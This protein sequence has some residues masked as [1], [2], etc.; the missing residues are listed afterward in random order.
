MLFRT[1]T[2]LKRLNK[3]SAKWPYCLINPIHAFITGKRGMNVG[4]IPYSWSPLDISTLLLIWKQKYSA[5]YIYPTH[6]A[7][8]HILLILFCREIIQMYFTKTT[9]ERLAFGDKSV[10][11]I[12]YWSM[13]FIVY[14]LIY[15]VFFSF[16][17][18]SLPWFYGNSFSLPALPLSY[19]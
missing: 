9:K 10:Y 17:I 16:V 1:Y 5:D 12:H 8:S 14:L 2:N 19:L 11:H 13:T 7:K 6:I 4:M 3:N 15:I 18:F